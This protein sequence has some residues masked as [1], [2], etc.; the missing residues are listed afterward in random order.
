MFKIFFIIWVVLKRPVMKVALATFITMIIVVSYPCRSHASLFTSAEVFP[1]FINSLLEDWELGT[2]KLIN[3][4]RPL[5][6]QW[7]NI[8][9]FMTERVSEGSGDLVKSSSAK[10][11][12]GNPGGRYKGNNSGDSNDNLEIAHIYAI[13]VIVVIV[14][15]ITSLWNIISYT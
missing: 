15:I 11:M 3:V 14:G 2:Q 4:F 1:K 6:R 8:P 13:L 5:N 10:N 7:I 9:K 12:Q